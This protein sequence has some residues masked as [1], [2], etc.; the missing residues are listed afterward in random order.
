MVCKCQGG[1]M[2]ENVIEYLT[3]L[4]LKKKE[5]LTKDIM[6]DIC[7]RV[8]VYPLDMI[9]EAFGTSKLVSKML[10]IK[11]EKQENCVID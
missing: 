3:F 6:T 2:E 5:N 9:S 8:Q 4:D 11:A 7:S 10:S 1:K